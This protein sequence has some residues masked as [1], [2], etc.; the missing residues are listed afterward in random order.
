MLRNVAESH[1]LARVLCGQRGQGVDIANV[2]KDIGLFCI[3]K[4][5]VE[6]YC[7]NRSL[8]LTLCN[9]RDHNNHHLSDLYLFKIKSVLV[10]RDIG[11]ISY[12]F[13]REVHLLKG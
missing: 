9:L 4:K 11:E 13:G 12:N 3:R 1:D 6:V 5:R 7:L 10:F 2:C 8:F